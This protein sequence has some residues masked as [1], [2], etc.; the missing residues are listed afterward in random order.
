V[1]P[2]VPLDAGWPYSRSPSRLRPSGREHDRREH[3]E[4]Q[5]STII[6]TTAL[7]VAVLAATPVGQAA[8]KFVLGKNS[9]GAAQL[10]KNAVT[11]KKI[12][13]PL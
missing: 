3:H 10:K 7:V 9:V 2:A 4:R 5:T 13:K 12:A 8:G 1:R 11:G 6:A